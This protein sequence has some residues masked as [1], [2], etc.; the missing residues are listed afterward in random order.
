MNSVY[1]S[2]AIERQLTERFDLKGSTIGRYVSQEEQ[3][4]LG[5]RAVLKDLN[6]V[7]HPNDDRLRIGPTSKLAL[8]KQLHS[9]IALLQDCGVIDYSLLV[10]VSIVSQHTRS[11]TSTSWRY[12]INRLTQRILLGK[13]FHSSS[14]D[15]SSLSSIPGERQGQPVLYYFGLIDFLQPFNY[16][17]LFEYRAKSLRYKSVSYSCIPPDL[18]AKRFLH[19]MDQYIA[20]Y[21]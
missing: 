13:F 12:M 20:W 1:P 2:Q 3:E 16:K 7:L 6:L 14:H 5:H 15:F 9:D 17:K 21:Q 10:G 4:R 18:Y 11:V 19:F 8:M